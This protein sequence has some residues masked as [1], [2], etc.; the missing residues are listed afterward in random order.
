MHNFFLALNSNGVPVRFAG[1]G[2]GRGLNL[3]AG[4][5]TYCIYQPI[6]FIYASAEKL[7]LHCVKGS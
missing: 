7:D 1:A 4:Q 6:E 2:R 5:G 3:R